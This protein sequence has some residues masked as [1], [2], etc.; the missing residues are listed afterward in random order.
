MKILHVITSLELGGAERLLTEVVPFQKQKG[1]L[2][3]VMILSDKNA[4]FKDNLEKAGIEVVV[5]KKNSI[6]SLSNVFDILREIKKEDYDIVHSHLVHAQYWTRLARL[7]DRNKRRKYITT[8]HSTSNRRRK[9]ELLRMLDRFVF[10]GYDKIVSISEAT[11]ESLKKWLKRNDSHFEII[12]N[13]IDIEK[14]QNSVGYTKETLGF[15][16]EDVLLMMVSRFHKSKNQKGVLDSLKWLPVKYKLIFVGDGALEDETKEYCNKLFLNSRVKFLGMR[17]DIPELLKSADIVI[18][19]S[20]FEGFGI[21]A[22]EGMASSKPVIASDVPGLR[23]VVEGAG[24]IVNGEKELAKGVLSLRNRAEYE[25]V[26]KKCFE[27]SKK[28]TLEWCADSYLKLYDKEL[29]C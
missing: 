11:Q 4:V 6:K 29:Q 9:H 15:K 13:G 20:H 28:Y 17:K 3:K 25:K 12:Y 23:D 26:A 22:L 10:D 16:E 14:F 18:Q 19:Y 27:R 5:C 21:T 1:N 2:V 8:E 7:F 24:I